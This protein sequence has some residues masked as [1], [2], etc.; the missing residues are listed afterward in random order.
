M[1][2]SQFVLISLG[3][4]FGIPDSVMGLTFLSFG[5][6]MP[7]SISSILMVRKV[8]NYDF[9]FFK[10]NLDLLIIFSNTYVN[11]SYSKGWTWYRCF[12][13]TGFKYFGYFFIAW[14]AMVCKEFT[15]MEQ[16]KYESICADWIKRNTIYHC[17]VICFNNITLFDSFSV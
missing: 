7:E 8:W 9:F 16:H 5:N 1:N 11:F 17:I 13:F 2:K 15:A 3:F 4:T 6:C 14:G 10:K 12:K